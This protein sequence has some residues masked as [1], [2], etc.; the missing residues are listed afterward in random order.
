[1]CY[2]FVL[3]EVDFSDYWLWKKREKDDSRN[4]ISDNVIKVMWDVSVQELNEEFQQELWHPVVLLIEPNKGLQ[5]KNSIQKVISQL[6]S[7][8]CIIWHI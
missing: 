3:F 4:I 8:S 6:I 5:F 7:T 1:M 2:F